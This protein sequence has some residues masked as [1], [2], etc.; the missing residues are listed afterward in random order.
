MSAV[1]GISKNGGAGPREPLTRGLGLFSFALGLPQLL[2]PGRVNRLI[3]VRDDA[4]SRMLM[5]AVGV[6][7]IVAGVGIF[8][9]RQ[10]TEWI[11]ARVA[12]DTMDLA[13]L[14]A[15][16]RAGSDQPARTL[17]ATGAVAGAFAA[18]L[19]DGVRLTRAD[20]TTEAQEQ[21]VHLK[22]SIT[23][24]RDREELYARWRDVTSFPEF[25]AHLEE[26]TVSGS[27]RSHWKARAPLGMNVEW[28]AEITEDVP[29]ER[30]SWRSLEGS[31][32]DNSGTVRF[33]A[34]PGDQG[35][36]IHLELRYAVPG[37]AVG[38]LLAKLFGEDPAMQI[39]DDLR[40]FKQIVETGEI[41]RSDGSP[42]GQLAK[43]QAKPRPAHPLPDDEL[44]AASPGGTS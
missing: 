26:V 24:R 3:G 22:G 40:R 27:E 20:G 21:P 43:R 19:F 10:P 1:P 25:M 34:A 41:A 11:W 42:E 32:I 30:I 18:D 8:S 14:G 23:V 5:R 31:R 37:G 35:T 2:A 29:A 38:G 15:A 16:L 12:G 13:L 17:V 9:R 6:R 33:V 28:D 4:T 7:E 44:A 36:E 39:K